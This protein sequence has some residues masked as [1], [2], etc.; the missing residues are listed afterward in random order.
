MVELL[1]CILPAKALKNQQETDDHCTFHV[2]GNL[3]SKVKNLPRDRENK[4]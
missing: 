1:E 3:F 4:K 2:A